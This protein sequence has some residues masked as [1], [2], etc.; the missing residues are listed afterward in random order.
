MLRF[1]LKETIFQ[2]FPGGACPKPP[3]IR[4]AKACLAILHT[5]ASLSVLLCPTTNGELQLPL[6]VVVM[7]LQIYNILNK[8]AIAN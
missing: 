3:R 7:R 1:N 8:L 6:T 2:N 4:Q 5:A